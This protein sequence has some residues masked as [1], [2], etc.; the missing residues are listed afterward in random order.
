MASRSAPNRFRPTRR[1]GLGRCRTPPARS[2]P[3]PRTRATVATD[4]LR[5]AGRPAR[6]VLASDHGSVAPTFDAVATVEVTVVDAGGVVVPNANDLISFQ[7][8]GPG[9]LAAVDSG[10]T[11]A[12]S[13][14]KPPSAAPS[15]AAASHW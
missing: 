6:I 15:R 9:V 14:F 5:T 8:S 3:W 7:V 11:R 1:R 4:E 13:R 10:T 12:T 2:G